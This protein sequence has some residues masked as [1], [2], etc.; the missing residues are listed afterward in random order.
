MNASSTRLCAKKW[1]E[2]ILPNFI[3]DSQTVVFNLKANKCARPQVLAKQGTIQR[4]AANVLLPCPHP[5]NA[6][7]QHA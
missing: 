1:I 2:D 7:G 6:T 3:R 4:R 5:Y